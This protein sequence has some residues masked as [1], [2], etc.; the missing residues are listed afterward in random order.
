MVIV[1]GASFIAC[2]GHVI[3]MRGVA[4]ER[5]RDPPGPA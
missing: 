2:V 1:V 4:M 3:A 5:R